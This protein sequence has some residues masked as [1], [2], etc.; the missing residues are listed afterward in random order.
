MVVPV[1]NELRTLTTVINS[2]PTGHVGCC[3]AVHPTE[4]QSFLYIT[5]L[6][7]PLVTQTL[8]SLLHLI[9]K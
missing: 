4:P 3:T 9:R 7:T 2:V 6:R 1:S 8:H 5:G